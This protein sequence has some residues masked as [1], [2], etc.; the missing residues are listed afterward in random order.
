MRGEREEEQGLFEQA[1]LTAYGAF[2]SQNSGQATYADIAQQAWQAAA[3]FMSARKKRQLSRYEE[4]LKKYDGIES[5][6]RIIELDGNKGKVIDF[7]VKQYVGA[8][9]PLRAYAADYTDGRR[10]SGQIAIALFLE[11]QGEPPV[12]KE[13]RYYTP[14]PSTKPDTSWYVPGQLITE[15]DRI[16]ARVKNKYYSNTTSRRR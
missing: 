16:E 6:K 8:D 5:L 15:L 4:V 10:T 12:V 1:A 2:L 9:S 14:A 13:T 11:K 7:L 3:D